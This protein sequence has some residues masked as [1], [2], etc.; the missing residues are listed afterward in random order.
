MGSASRVHSFLGVSMVELLVSDEVAG[1]GTAS[2]GRD[3]GTG[4]AHGSDEGPAGPVSGGPPRSSSTMRAPERPGRAMI[5]ELPESWDEVVDVVV[6]GSG[7][8]ALTAATLAAD[9]G[10]RTIVVEKTDMIGGT[11]AVSG[12]V[13]WIPQ[14]AHM[15]EGGLEDSREEALAYV[16][17]L[18]MGVEPAP[19]LLE[20]FVDSA[21]VAL[22]YLET[23]TPVTMTS[24]SLFPDYYFPYDVPGKK[25]G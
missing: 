6:V 22:D 3:A 2:R 4:P 1:S 10:A 17:H 20:V 16:R 13:L 18:A 19:A 15:A 14:N 8:A 21:P 11:T 7:G 25:A 24:L 5:V 12:G 23:N 9:G